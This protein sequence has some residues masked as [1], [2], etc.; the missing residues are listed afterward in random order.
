MKRRETSKRVCE[1]RGS[2]EVCD[3]RALGC[4]N[5]IPEMAC[6]GPRVEIP[7]VKLADEPPAASEESWAKTGLAGEADWIAPHRAVFLISVR[8]DPVEN[9]EREIQMERS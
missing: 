8:F 5:A 2:K 9:N 6:L 1:V 7:F 4:R 3:V